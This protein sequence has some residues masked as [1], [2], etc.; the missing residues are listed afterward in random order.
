MKNKY[1]KFSD[2]E[3]LFMIKLNDEEALNQLIDNYRIH[4]KTLALSYSLKFPKTGVPVEDLTHI[5]LTDVAV[6]AERFDKNVKDNDFIS[7]WSLIAGRDIAQYV[8]RE[9]YKCRAK[10]FD[11]VALDANVDSDD[12]KSGKASNLLGV[13]DNEIDAKFAIEEII[14]AIKHNKY[15]LKKVQI[16]IALDI[17]NEEEPS[18]TMQKYQISKSMYYRISNVLKNI[19]RDY[20]LKQRD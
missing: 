4:A 6:A 20:Y 19:I 13:S 12:E 10:F 16:Q 11:G 14:E 1:S 5:A 7:F 17:F 15:G 8:Q 2:D 3:L 9:S 18:I